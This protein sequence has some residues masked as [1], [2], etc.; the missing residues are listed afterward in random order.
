M[1]LR[2][3]SAALPRVP[4]ARASSNRPAASLAVLH[5]GS[6]AWSWV[7]VALE[8]PSSPLR[9]YHCGGVPELAI[10][11]ADLAALQLATLGGDGGTVLF[12]QGALVGATA[13]RLRKS[14][15]GDTFILV[16]AETMAMWLRAFSGSRWT[17]TGD[18]E[19]FADAW[20]WWVED[21]FAV[22]GIMPLPPPLNVPPVPPTSAVVAVAKANRKAA[23]KPHP[24]KNTRRASICLM[25][26]TLTSGWYSST[27]AGIWPRSSVG[28]TT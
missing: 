27:S 11:P 12:L 3:Q 23:P 6:R 14:Y 25:V 20:R 1:G 24:K 28:R 5:C 2:G 7:I 16:M 15:G 10:R 17:V 26:A 18:K 21:Q 9:M 22:V 4:A 19:K 13:L 8:P